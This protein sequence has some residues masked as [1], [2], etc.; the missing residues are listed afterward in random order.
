MEPAPGC[1]G[2]RKS[3]GSRDPTTLQ[4]SSSPAEKTTPSHVSRSSRRWIANQQQMAHR[5][6]LTTAVLKLRNF[7]PTSYAGTLPRLAAERRSHLMI[8]QR[9]LQNQFDVSRPVSDG[10]VN[11]TNTATASTNWPI[12]VKQRAEKLK[13]KEK[14]KKSSTS[15]KFP[16]CLFKLFFFCLLFSHLVDTPPY[17]SHS[18]T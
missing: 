18:C 10:P 4:T 1:V 11:S 15:I 14:K 2:S 6:I 16:S 5:K 9:H 13:K 17:P 7:S 3:S 12:L 8:M